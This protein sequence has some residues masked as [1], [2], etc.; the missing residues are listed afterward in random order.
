MPAAQPALHPAERYAA[1]VLTGR[2]VAGRWVKRACE[3]HLRDRQLAAAGKLRGHWFDAAAAQYVIDF[4]ALLH[5]SKGPY[6]GQVFQLEPWQ[7]FITWSL[8]GWK[9]ADGRRRFRKAL[10][11]VGRGNGKTTMLAG[12]GLY[13]FLADGEAGPDCYSA[14][15]KRDQARLIH[16]E[17]IAMVRRSPDLK[18]R[19]GIFKD[20]LHILATRAKFVPLGA[21]E[22]GEHG[23]NAHFAGVDELHVHKTRKMWDVLETSIIKRAQPLIV[24]ITTAGELNEPD[25]IWAEIHDYCLEVLDGHHQDDAWFSYIATLDPQDLE[26]ENWANPRCWLKANPNLGVSVQRD[27]LEEQVREAQR[28]PRKRN[29]VLRLHLNSPTVQEDLSAIPIEQWDACA[30]PVESEPGE[31]CWAGLDAASH[32]DLAALVLVWPPFSGRP[33]RWLPF[34]FIP[35]DTAAER[36]QKDRIPYDTWIRSGHIE[37]T[38]GN[39]VDLDLIGQRIEQL[40]TRFNIR[41]LVKDPWNTLQ[42]GTQLE[43]KFG[44][45]I[46]PFVVDFPQTINNFSGPTKEL[47]EVV[48]PNRALAHAGHP[49]LRWMAGNLAVKLDSNGNMRPDKRASRKKID[50]M[51]AGLQAMKRAMTSPAPGRFGLIAV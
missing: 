40:K 47:L 29:T 42:I 34:F 32:I 39:A 22:S 6:A 11:E 7:Q 12:Y 43:A 45:T 49:V 17:A 5:H 26:G 35:R 30:G 8:F 46:Q 1:D 44:S 10:I 16:A 18:K 36:Q 25:S 24:A 33:W 3:R 41:E 23:L 27:F 50:G 28:K 21:E 15:T 51:V 13:M 2:M 9:R 38:G 48:L 14:A 4:F 20:N 19:I 37:A 31:P